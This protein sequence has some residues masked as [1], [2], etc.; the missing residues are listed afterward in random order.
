MVELSEAQRISIREQLAE[1]DKATKSIEVALK[2]LEDVRRAIEDARAMFLEP[3]GD[4]SGSCEGCTKMLFDGE[5]GYR[6]EDGIILC[7]DCGPT[8]T[9]WK[10]NCERVINDPSLVDEPDEIGF[11]ND[12]LKQ[13]AEHL[14]GGGSLTDKL[15]AFPL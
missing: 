9:D 6:E 5:L 1:F 2:P 15:P 12:A 13:I 7:V 4:V 14:A 3:Y 8:Y 10:S 11:A